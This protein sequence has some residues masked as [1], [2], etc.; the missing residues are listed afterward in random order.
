MQHAE[1]WPAAV[2][3][4]S[5]SCAR[6]SRQ[7]VSGPAVAAELRAAGFETAEPVVVPDEQPAIQDAIQ[8]AIRAAAGPC[9]L[10]VTTGGTGISSRDVTPEATAAVCERMLEGVAELMRAEGRRDTPLAVLSR[11]VCGIS[12]TTIILNVPGSPR[13]AVNSLR[14]ALPVLPHALELLSGRTEHA[15]DVAGP[16]AERKVPRV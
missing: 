14:A 12:G 6:G 4:V 1:R 8:A 2:I 3:T 11:G 7:D 10:V 15:G 5:D 16:P 13:G 9:S